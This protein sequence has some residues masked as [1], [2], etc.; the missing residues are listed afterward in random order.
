MR[1]LAAFT[2]S[3]SATICALHLARAWLSPPLKSHGGRGGR[4]LAALDRDEASACA[5]SDT[6]WFQ[7]RKPMLPPTTATPAATDTQPQVRRD[8]VRRTYASR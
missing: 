7:T 3:L 8:E 4:A 1:S 6:F 5:S 2:V